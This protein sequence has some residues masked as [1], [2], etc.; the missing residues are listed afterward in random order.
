MGFLPPMPPYRTGVVLPERPGSSDSKPV[1]L[2]RL[3]LR[4]HLVGQILR[5]DLG[6]NE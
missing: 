5:A 1:L 6:I 2:C 4:L 3:D